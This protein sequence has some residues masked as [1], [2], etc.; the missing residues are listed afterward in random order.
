MIQQ[1]SLF[2]VG[3]FDAEKTHSYKKAQEKKQTD[4][5]LLNILG[6]EKLAKRRVKQEKLKTKLQ[7]YLSEPQSPEFQAE[8]ERLRATPLPVQKRFT[9]YY[10]LLGVEPNATKREIYNAYRRKA[11][12]MHPDVGGSN[13][14]FQ[15]LQ[16]AY[17]KLL[18]LAP[19]E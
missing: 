2:D 19:K 9:A 1:T 6:P 14:A 8:I 11:R 3:K 5:W 4:E 12:K 18:K 15:Q 7:A 17:H 10:A 13:E 16:D